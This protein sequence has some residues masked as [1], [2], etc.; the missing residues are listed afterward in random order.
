M[1]RHEGEMKLRKFVAR[2]LKPV[3]PFSWDVAKSG[4][5]LVNLAGVVENRLPEQAIQDEAPAESNMRLDTPDS[6]I[7]EYPDGAPPE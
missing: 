6:G 3:F 5:M 1:I 2:N 4:G 7:I